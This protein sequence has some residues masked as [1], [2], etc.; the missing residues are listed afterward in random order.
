MTGQPL[1]E[2]GRV[3]IYGFQILLRGFPGIFWGIVAWFANPLWVIALLLLFLKRVKAA[4]AVSL[5]SLAIA[6]TSFLA[7]G[8]DLGVWKSDVYH[9]VIEGFLPGCFLWMAS[10]A[11]VPLAYWLKITNKS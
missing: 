2:A 11:V 1:T 5:V 6:F 8:K 7:I 3:R 4:L 10:L 9:Q